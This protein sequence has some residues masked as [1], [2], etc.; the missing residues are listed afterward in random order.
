MCRRLWRCCCIN[1]PFLVPRPAAYVLPRLPSTAQLPTTTTAPG[2]A[3]WRQ[4]V[5][6]ASNDGA[7]LPAD[8]G[9]HTPRALGWGAVGGWLQQ[10][11]SAAMRTLRAAVCARLACVAVQQQTA[12]HPVTPYPPAH[13]AAHALLLCTRP[14][15]RA[16][17]QSLAGGWRCAAAWWC[18]CSLHQTMSGI[19][20][21]AGPAAANTRLMHSPLAP[22]CLLALAALSLR[23]AGDAALPAA[24]LAIAVLKRGPG[25][26]AAAAGCHQQTQQQQR[27]R[28]Q[29]PACLPL[30]QQGP[31]R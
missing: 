28:P 7:G 8:G 14:R 15:P 29:V 27:V 22:F 19:E 12:A 13:D 26:A 20:A 11:P 21:C 24:R 30:E 18:C 1:P 10:H 5:P 17:G 31:G 3:G 6:A 25:G 23:A 4:R 16:R 9:E 2:C